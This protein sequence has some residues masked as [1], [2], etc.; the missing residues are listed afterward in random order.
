MLNEEQ[1]IVKREALQKSFQAKEG[2]LLFLGITILLAYL[3]V[4]TS[5]KQAWPHANFTFL[6]WILA[7]LYIAG[8]IFVIQDI[9][10]IIKTSK[11]LKTLRGFSISYTVF[12][13]PED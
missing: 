11:I 4:A 10:R 8:C 12:S 5:N 1:L 13:S 9:Y 7:L 2:L 6:H 3:F